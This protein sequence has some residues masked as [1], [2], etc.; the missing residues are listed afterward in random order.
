MDTIQS[1]APGLSPLFALV[2]VS[3]Q[4]FEVYHLIYNILPP[5]EQAY[6]RAFENFALSP[7]YLCLN[8]VS[9]VRDSVT[10]VLHDFVKF[11]CIP[12]CR[13]YLLRLTLGRGLGATTY[14]G[15]GKCQ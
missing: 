12:S 3:A 4:I 2:L 6:C 14:H 13:Y 15:V 11:S 10:N 8:R 7:V 5:K 9:S 1:I